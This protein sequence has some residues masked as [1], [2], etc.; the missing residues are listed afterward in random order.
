[1]ARAVG[2]IKTADQIAIS[3][4][5]TA[6]NAAGQTKESAGQLETFTS[7]A[8]KCHQETFAKFV[9]S[10]IQTTSVGLDSPRGDRS[11]TSRYSGDRLWPRTSGGYE[12]TIDA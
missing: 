5:N 7:S 9:L 6:V 4:I 8:E 10:M 12:V 3:I 11:V 2:S 1:M